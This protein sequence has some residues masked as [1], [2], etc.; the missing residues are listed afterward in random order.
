MFKF[1]LQSVLEYREFLED[2]KKMELAEKQ[3]V[4]LENQK[5]G[6]RLRQIR[7]QYHQAMREETAS[8]DVSVTMLSFY[9]SYIHVVEH[10]IE[11]QDQRT[12]DS[13]KDMVEKQDELVEARKQKEV[14]IRAREKAHEKYRYEEEMKNQKILDEVSAI[15]YVRAQRG[16]DATAQATR[17]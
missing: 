16:L 12:E 2:M 17:I 3:R 1:R 4:Y 15:K 13:R 9:H 5:R 6:E 10:Q 8:E 7:N 14:M 11:T